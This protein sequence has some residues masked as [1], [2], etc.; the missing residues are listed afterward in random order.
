MTAPPSV[1][2]A[3]SSCACTCS[4]I[5]ANVSTSVATMSANGAVCSA[6]RPNAPPSSWMAHATTSPTVAMPPISVFISSNFAPKFVT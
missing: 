6:V 1:D 5:G 2:S 4:T 3:G